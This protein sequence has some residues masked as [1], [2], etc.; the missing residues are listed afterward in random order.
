MRKKGRDKAQSTSSDTFAIMMVFGIA[1]TLT[2]AMG[3]MVMGVGL[4]DSPNAQVSTSFS[5]QPSSHASVTLVTV[6]DADGV[7]VTGLRDPDPVESDVWKTHEQGTIYIDG[8]DLQTGQ[9][10]RLPYPEAVQPGDTV[11]VVSYEGQDTSVVAEYE[12]PT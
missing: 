10:V 8:K 1:I 3:M 11:K 7:M 9:T 6:G 12:V 2:S 5:W 4:P